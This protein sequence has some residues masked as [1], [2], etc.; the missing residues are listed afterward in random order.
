VQSSNKCSKVSVS[1][2]H[3]WHF[4]SSSP[5][6]FVRNMFAKYMFLLTFPVLVEF[7]LFL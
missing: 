4:A 5:Y 1:T 2:L 6:I 3:S 7:Y